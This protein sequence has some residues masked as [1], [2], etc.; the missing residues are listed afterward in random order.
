MAQTMRFFGGRG[1]RVFSTAQATGAFLPAGANAFLKRRLAEALGLGF[2]AS[3]LLLLTSIL[4]YTPGDPSL[5]SA[6]GATVG[7]FLG[8]PGAIAADLALQGFGF[9]ALL[10]VLAL[11]AWGW[12][13]ATKR[14]VSVWGVRVILLLAAMVL[15]AAG[16][17]AFPVPKN[18]PLVAPLGGVSGALIFDRLSALGQTFGLGPETLGPTFSILATGVFLPALG[19]SWA[20][21]AATGRAISRGF[22]I[23]RLGAS[24]GREA[25]GIVPAWRGALSEPDEEEMDDEDPYIEPVS[26]GKS[27]ATDE[28][29]PQTRTGLVASK[30]PRLKTGRRAKAERQ[31]KLNLGGNKEYQ[32]PPLDLLD[33]PESSDSSGM[34]NKESLQQN[35]KF[36][37]S[38]L[39]DFGVRGE[40]VKVR[41]GPVVTLY[42]LE[43]AP[44]TKTSR[45]IGL[46][47]DIARSMSAVSVRIAVV[48][49]Q[50]VIGIELPNV[51]REMVNLREILA[52]EPFEKTSAKLPLALGKDIGGAPVTVDLARMPHLLIAGTT[53]SGKSVAMNTMIL[54]LLYRLSPEECRFIMIDP[55][56]LELS[57]YEGIPHLLTPVVTEPSKAIVA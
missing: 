11:M 36:L 34:L 57:V 51:S 17:S 42:E 47:D 8:A 24:R 44:G 40:I 23:L 1:E 28:T 33:S 20:D 25:F 3:A 10:P 46:S 43:P 31:G 5:N 53:G 56:M 26:V 32:T 29:K 38:I 21:W 15:L 6:G 52:S 39:E 9:A 2:F 30:K 41:P 37:G 54:S 4:S 13:T 35:A 48:P 16:L 45:V 27:S 7:N 22:A 19:L 18:W 55:K 49:G 50:S 12:R 14:G